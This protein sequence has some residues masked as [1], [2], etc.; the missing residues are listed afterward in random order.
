LGGYFLP[1]LSRE[2][3]VG[4]VE[5]ANE[6]VKF[7]RGILPQRGWVDS[8]EDGKRSLLIFR[9]KKEVEEREEC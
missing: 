3:R 4:S 5:A 7:L 9:V 1:Y 8:C 6:E 2:E